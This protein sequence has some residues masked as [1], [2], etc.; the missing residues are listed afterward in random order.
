MNTRVV[1]VGVSLF[2]LLSC[3]PT[4]QAADLDVAQRVDRLSSSTGSCFRVEA[5][6]R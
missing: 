1:V 6:T 3:S 4:D 2:V 5:A